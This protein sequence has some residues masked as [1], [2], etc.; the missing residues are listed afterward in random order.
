MKNTYLTPS[1]EPIELVSENVF[2]GS[3]TEGDYYGPNMDGYD[4]DI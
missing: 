3:P 4:W 2:A 1:A